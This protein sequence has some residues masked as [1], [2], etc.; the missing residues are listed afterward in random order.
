VQITRELVRPVKPL[1][2]FNS[3][4]GG[5][6]AG[7][8]MQSCAVMAPNLARAATR[9]SSEPT[10]KSPGLDPNVLRATADAVEAVRMHYPDAVL[11]LVL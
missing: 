7:K 5:S 11:A 4:I 8:P 3:S 2:P 10:G 9:D 6:S 1:T